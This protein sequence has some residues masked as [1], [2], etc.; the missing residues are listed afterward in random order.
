[1]NAR[2]RPF[3]IQKSVIFALMMRELRG[4]YSRFKLGYLW[5]I[6]EPV[7]MIGIL[8]AIR[9][10]RGSGPIEGI[11]FPLFFA[12]GIITYSFFSGTI[13]GGLGAVE[14]SMSLMGYQRVKPIDPI[15]SRIILN[16]IIGL[17]TL[18][19][20][21]TVM[22]WVGYHFTM[23]SISF[24]ILPII[25]LT[26][27][28]TGIG[29]GAAMISPQ[30]NEFKKVFPMLL[31]PLFFAS[32]IFF[33]VSSMPESVQKYM[34]WNPI[35]I[36]I[37]QVRYYLFEDYELLNGSLVRLSVLALGS[38][39]LGLTIYRRYRIKVVTTGTIKQT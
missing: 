35:T 32:G 22:H 37:E 39:V 11:P 8:S 4:N 2:Q 33:S 12:S 15:L 16:S 29:I 19:I 23:K 6:L 7:A 10:L 21:L 34:L 38:L 20:I 25:L 36:A 31:R 18:V 9:L 14:S 30:I 24:V 26:L 3:E 5:A 13:R 1:M 17:M 28:S 27:F